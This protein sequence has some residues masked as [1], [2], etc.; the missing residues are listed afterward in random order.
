MEFD[1]WTQSLLSAMS[2]LWASVAAFIPRLFGALVVVLLGFVV[3]KLLDTLLSKVL[4]K[5]GLDRLMAGTGLTKLLGRAGIRIPVSALIGKV[6]Y[7][8][9][10][11]I[12]LV[13]AAESLGLERVSATLDMLALY[14]PKVFGAALILLAGVLLAQ[15]LSGLVRGAAE[16]VGLDYANGL[17]RM[18]QGL[19]IIISISVAIGQ[20]EVKTELLNYVIAIV[21]ITVGLAVALAFGLGSRELVSQILAGIYVRELYE[22]G[23]RVRLADIEG[24]IEEIGTVKTLLLTD[25]GELTS[26]ANRV[27]L[28]QRVGSR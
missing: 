28:E 4:A 10:L 26:V 13:S 2:S 1:P 27:L 18:A 6:V 12:F 23:Q 11:L 22:V 5:V 8:F 20:L 15:L 14:V 19:V 25:D 17:A 9:V 24:Q 3:A 21:L 7:W 16:S